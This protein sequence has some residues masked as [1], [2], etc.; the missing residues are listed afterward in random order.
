VI[1]KPMNHAPATQIETPKKYF[2]VKAQQ[3][4]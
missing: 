4:G 1:T 3:S 2:N